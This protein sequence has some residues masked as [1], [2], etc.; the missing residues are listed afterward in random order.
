[1]NSSDR[2]QGLGGAQ[3]GIIWQRMEGQAFQAE[4]TAEQSIDPMTMQDP[5]QESKQPAGTLGGVVGDAIPPRNPLPPPHPHHQKE[6]S[7]RIGRGAREQQFK[8][9]R[10]HTTGCALVCALGRCFIWS[11]ISRE[12]EAESKLLC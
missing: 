6:G 5:D 2:K 9:L 7:V 8:P 1:M 11:C 4:G 3:H 10:E 12:K